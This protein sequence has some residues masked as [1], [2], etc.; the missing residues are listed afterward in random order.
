[1]PTTNP[2]T[3]AAVAAIT[4]A[5]Q[6]ISTAADA[7]RVTLPAA[8]AV[9]G[10][11]LLD[12]IA[13][14]VGTAATLHNLAAD[15][16]EDDRT[17]RTAELIIGGNAY[18][19]EGR[20]LLTL[21]LCARTGLPV[22]DWLDDAGEVIPDECRGGRAGHDAILQALQSGAVPGSSDVYR[23]RILAAES[24]EELDEIAKELAGLAC[25]DLPDASEDTTTTVQEARSQLLYD[26]AEMDIDA[27]A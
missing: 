1:M 15:M 13:Q 26:L 9:A 23:A 20:A 3:A 8:G 6:Q 27:A 24:R 17:P 7:L 12:A 16:A 11:V 19:A 22:G 5:A 2:T 14:A 18:R 25:V 10:R 4:A 21:P